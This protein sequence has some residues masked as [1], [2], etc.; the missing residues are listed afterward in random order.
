M[1]DKT[2]MQKLYELP[3]WVL[4][5][6]G[7][8]IIALLAYGM[9]LL[10]FGTSKGPEPVDAG[11]VIINMPDASGDEFDKSRADLY[12]EGDYA[13]RRRG[14]AIDDYWDTLGGDLVSSGEVEQ[15]EDDF[16]YLDNGEYTEAEK[17]L[18]RMGVKTRAEVDREHEEMAAFRRSLQHSSGGASSSSGSQGRMTRAQKDSQYNARLEQAIEMAARLQAMNGTGDAPAA[19][20][21]GDDDESRHIEIEEEPAVLPLES[22]SDDD[23]ISSLEGP[24]RSVGTGTAAVRRPV[25]ATFLKDE[26]ISSGA[27]VIIRLMQDL[28]LSDGTQIPVNTH[29]TGICNIS[30]RLKIQVTS[31]HYGGKMYATNLTIFDNDGTEGIYCP[32]VEDAKRKSQTAKM[33]AGEVVSGVGSIA[34]SALSGNPMV[35]RVARSSLS[36]VTSSINSDGSMSVNVTAGYEFYVYENVKEEQG[37][38]KK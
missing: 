7:V 11:P 20:D 29:L 1:A 16:S 3:K 24:S 27:R 21:A 2:F 34:G 17:R 15:E 23:I 13:G 4:A 12:R 8:V 25:K 33:I 19:G 37:R 35:G 28:T 5:T 32:L 18:I 38:G 30:R 22:F 14:D 31:L 26:K 9:Y 36:G 6:G 10:V